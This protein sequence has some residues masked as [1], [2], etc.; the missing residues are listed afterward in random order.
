MRKTAK[1]NIALGIAALSLV[2]AG[3]SLASLTSSHV[4]ANHA[5]YDTVD[6]SLG[7]KSVKDEN[8]D[9]LVMPNETVSIVPE[10]ENKGA[11]SYIRLN[12]TVKVIR[13]DGKEETFS[14]DLIVGEGKNWQRG[15]DGRFYYLKKFSEKGKQNIF[16]RFTIPSSWGDEYMDGRVKVVITAE[17]IQSRN[18]SDEGSAMIG[19]WKGIRTEK[20]VRTRTYN[21]EVKKK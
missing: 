20:T 8:G 17:A 1:R 10:I 6:I 11:V 12:E 7:T 18:F 4:I 13:K 16:T 9:G 15:K 5:Q 3:S 19:K 21:L 14:P 2:I